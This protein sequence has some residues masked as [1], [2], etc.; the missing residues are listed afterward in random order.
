VEVPE[1]EESPDDAEALR[2][3]Q[4]MLGAKIAGAT[5]EAG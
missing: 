2:R 3:V 4:E 5:P 1:E